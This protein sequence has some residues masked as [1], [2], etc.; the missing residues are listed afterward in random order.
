MGVNATLNV[1]KIVN[2]NMKI[3]QLKKLQATAYTKKTVLISEIE[4]YNSHKKYEEFARNNLGYA[5]P[6]E[7]KLILI[8]NNDIPPKKLQMYY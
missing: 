6:D 3:E 7:I 1:T 5:A 8:P 4:G 2:Y